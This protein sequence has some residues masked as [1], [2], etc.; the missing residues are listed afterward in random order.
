MD[1]F[2]TYFLAGMFGEELIRKM[3]T[4]PFGFMYLWL[5]GFILVNIC[6]ILLLIAIGLTGLFKVGIAQD[7]TILSTLFS[8]IRDLSNFFFIMIQPWGAIAASG[9]GLLFALSYYG[10]YRNHARQLKK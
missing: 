2:I 4:R 5:I 10:H 3:A 1:D 8:F 9:F 7:E 6:I